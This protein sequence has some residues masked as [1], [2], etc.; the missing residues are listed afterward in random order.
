MN[1]FPFRQSAQNASLARTI[2]EIVAPKG[3]T[4]VESSPPVKHPKHDKYTPKAKPQKPGVPAPVNFTPTTPRVSEPLK[5]ESV[6]VSESHSRAALEKMSITQLRALL[7][8]YTAKPGSGRELADIRGLLRAKGA[9]SVLDEARKGMGKTRYGQALKK[10][11]DAAERIKANPPKPPVNPFKKPV[12]E[13]MTPCEKSALARLKGANAEDLK[14]KGG[15]A[16]ERAHKRLHKTVKAVLGGDTP[17]VQNENVVRRTVE[18]VRNKLGGA[19]WKTDAE[20]DKDIH[21]TVAREDEAAARKKRE[22]ESERADKDRAERD[23]WYK[24]DA[25]RKRREARERDDSSSNSKSD[26]G[27]RHN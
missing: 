27:G 19:G 13:A 14:E 23:E 2:S 8:K 4:P 15:K 21:D 3:S 5:T 17:S 24:R 20:V 9:G 7:K 11:G 26:P 1:P 12:Q 22:A 25:E 16:G 6:E 18:R 10:L